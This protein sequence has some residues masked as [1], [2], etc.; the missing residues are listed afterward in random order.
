MT[1]THSDHYIAG[2][3]NLMFYWGE[4]NTLFRPFWES[5]KKSRLT[6]HIYI[7]ESAPIRYAGINLS[8]S[9]L[10]NQPQGQPQGGVQ[11]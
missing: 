7:A 9:G 3:H 1:A 8:I 4:R 5:K 6:M 10:I 11:W 2:Q